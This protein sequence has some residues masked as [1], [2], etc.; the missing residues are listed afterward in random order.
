MEGFGSINHFGNGSSQNDCQLI[1]NRTAS[2]PTDFDVTVQMLLFGSDRGNRGFCTTYNRH[3]AVTRLVIGSSEL[4]FVV[5]VVANHA[6]KQKVE[7]L[8]FFFKR[9]LFDRLALRPFLNRKDAVAV[10]DI[11]RFVGCDRGCV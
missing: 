11:D 9:T 3:H 1:G 5:V 2:G 8:P 7:L 4:F 6:G 10:R